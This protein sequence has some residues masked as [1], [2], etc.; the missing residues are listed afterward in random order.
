M[1]IKQIKKLAGGLYQLILDDTDII[2]FEDVILENKLL[3]AKEID[4]KL[5]AKLELENKY[6]SC[7]HTALKYL[8]RRLRSEYELKTYLSSKDFPPSIIDQTILKLQKQ[9][10]VNDAFFI[11]AF[12]NDKLLMT[13]W[14]PLKIKIELE[15][16]NLKGLDIATM[17]DPTLIDK[18]IKKIINRLITTNKRYST[19]LLKNK[20][21]NHLLNLGYSFDL[22][23]SYIKDIKVNDKV[24]YQKEY[25]RLYNR[26]KHSTPVDTLDDLVKKKLNQKGL[27]LDDS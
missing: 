13:N 15:K 10:Y 11:K 16:H 26:Y 25:T 17:I 19:S 23:G 4:G 9:G 24:I 22:I 7:Y 2:L 21:T 20:I 18:K 6:A 3:F 27:F 12:I 8:N 5:L 1:K 14:G